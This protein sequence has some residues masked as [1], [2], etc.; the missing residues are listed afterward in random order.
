M[1][2]KF[3]VLIKYLEKNNLLLSIC[4]LRF[5]NINTVSTNPWDVV[6]HHRLRLCCIQLHTLVV[7]PSMRERMFTSSY[8][9]AF[10]HRYS[11]IIVFSAI[12]IDSLTLRS[13]H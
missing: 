13:T 8:L 12:T 3:K 7:I 1:L 5:F 2:F 9:V 6:L 11:C 4:I 10:D